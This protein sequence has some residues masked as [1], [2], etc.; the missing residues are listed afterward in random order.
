MEKIKLEIVDKYVNE[1]IG[2]FH[3]SRLQSLEKLKLL[4]IL[5][6]KNPYLYK[7]KNLNTPELIVRGC[8]DAHISSNEETIFGNWL[9][10]LAIFINSEVYGGKKSGI[11]GIDLEFDL[12]NIRYI[13]NI[14]SGPHWGNASQVKKMIADFNT[15]KKTL[16]TSNS[17]LQII[18][19][20][21]CCY[22][23]EA[24]TDKGEYFKY[25]GQDFW[26]FISANDNLYIDIIKPLGT[27]AKTKNEEYEVLYNKRITRFALDF[28]NTFCT[29][30]GTIDWEKLVRF[31]SGKEKITLEGPSYHEG[32]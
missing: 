28:G 6:N 27:L 26:T 2:E 20:N 14:K 31:N 13:V 9:E 8:L 30:D 11:N 22:G 1:H 17:N 3:E 5:K 18:A 23:K 25:C 16:R 7:A 10:K 19:V 29:P 15:A 4:K 32:V 24:N 21:G 12:N